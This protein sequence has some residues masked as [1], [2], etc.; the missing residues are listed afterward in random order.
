MNARKTMEN[1]N[2]IVITMREDIGVAVKMVISS[3]MICTDVK[4]ER[5]NTVIEDASFQPRASVVFLNWNVQQCAHIRQSRDNF[6]SLNKSLIILLFT[7]FTS[8]VLYLVHYNVSLKIIGYV[9]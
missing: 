6:P 5:R 3:K 9:E 1:V 8:Y 2:I 4:V 7:D